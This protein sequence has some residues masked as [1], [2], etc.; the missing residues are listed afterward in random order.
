VADIRLYQFAPDHGAES[1]SSFCVKVQRALTL[2]GLD[3]EV[4]NVNPANLRKVNPQTGK[5]PV[6]ELQGRR[7]SDSSRILEALEQRAPSPALY[8][9]QPPLQGLNHILE[10]WADESFYWFNVYYRWVVDEHFAPFAEQAFGRMPVPLKWIVPTIARRQARGQT[11]SQGLGRLPREE[12]D[13]RLDEHLSALER[14][15]SAGAF[16]VDDSI[17][18]ADIALFSVLRGLWSPYMTGP[19]PRITARATVLQWMQ[20]VDAATRPERA[21]AVTA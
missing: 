13:R 4:E 8:P 16:L 19:R 7:I 18:S 1:A 9:S 5:L 12:V 10:D 17:R 6:L 20:R 11:E 3:Y 14:R 2:K 21:E 15:L